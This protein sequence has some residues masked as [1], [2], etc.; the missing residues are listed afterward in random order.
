M[1]RPTPMSDG[2]VSPILE[3]A[4]RPHTHPPVRAILQAARP[5]SAYTSKPRLPFF[6]T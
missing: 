3:R 6:L 1:E 4:A 2:V 5:T